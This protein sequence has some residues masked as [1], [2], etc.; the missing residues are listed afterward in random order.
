M[1]LWEEKEEKGRGEMG[2]I[3]RRGLCG[4]KHDIIVYSNNNSKVNE[5]PGFQVF[6]QPTSLQAGSGSGSS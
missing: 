5:R 2:F 3:L 1:V 4:S 6:L